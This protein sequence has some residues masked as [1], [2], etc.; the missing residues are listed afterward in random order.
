VREIGQRPHDFDCPSCPW[1]VR[2]IRRCAK[3]GDG[4][5][6]ELRARGAETLPPDPDAEEACA[7]LKIEQT[8]RAARWIGQWKHWHERGWGPHGPHREAQAPSFLE[9]MGAIDAELA[10][11][12]RERQKER[13]ADQ[14]ARAA[15][16]W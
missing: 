6:E 3:R 4:Q 15:G 12:E 16:V 11:M 8:P 10:A 2:L 9:A 14:R 7:L 1:D 5:G 13:D